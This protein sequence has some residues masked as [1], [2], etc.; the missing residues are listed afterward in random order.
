M[1]KNFWHNKKNANGNRQCLYLQITWSYLLWAAS[2]HPWCDA[3]N[4]S[5]Q[6]EGE[7]IADYKIGFVYNMAEWKLSINNNRISSAS[8]SDDEEFPAPPSEPII[9]TSK[10]RTSISE[11]AL[12]F[13]WPSFRRLDLWSFSLFLLFLLALLCKLVLTSFLFSFDFS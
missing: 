8:S 13:C 10:S 4:K 1:G 3:K 5:E 7:F 2:R 6:E 9:I 11:V 12:F